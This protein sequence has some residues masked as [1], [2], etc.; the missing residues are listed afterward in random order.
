MPNH[1]TPKRK[2]LYPVGPSIAYLEL[3][4]GH[5]ALVDWDDAEWLSSW[6]WSAYVPK[7]APN[8]VRAMRGG[9]TSMFLHR[10]IMGCPHREGIVDHINRRPLDNRRANLRL[11]TAA[12][13]SSNRGVSRRSKTGIK[14]VIVDGNQFIAQCKK[15]GKLYFG[16]RFPTA[17]EA[18]R[19]YLVLAEEIH[20][21]YGFKPGH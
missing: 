19:A 6:N 4:R 1:L 5:H 17:E 13:S 16:G 20:G 21:E 8:D 14:G 18:G 9:K 15:N 2:P 10:Q 7:Y 12:Q 3:S 11:V